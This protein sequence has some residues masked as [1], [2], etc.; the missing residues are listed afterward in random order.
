MGR[1][2]LAEKSIVVE[3]RAELQ[4]F[5]IYTLEEKCEWV[6]IMRKEITLVSLL[7]FT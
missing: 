6:F 4:G 3:L 5:C 7:F 2:R 1:E